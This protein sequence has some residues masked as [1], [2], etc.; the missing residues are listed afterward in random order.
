[1]RFQSNLKKDLNE[2]VR[3]EL[4]RLYRVAYRL[5]GNSV[6]SEDM[7]AQTLLQAAKGWR[8][9][10]GRHPSAWLYRILNNVYLREGAK[11][12]RRATQPIEDLAETAD[13]I[14]VEGL[15]VERMELERVLAGMAYLTPEQQVAVTLCDIEG[16]SYDEV[17]K[18]LEIPKGTLSSRLFRARQTLQEH[19][20][21][22]LSD[23]S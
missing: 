15:V 9:F 18:V 8:I 10:D 4:P 16:M 23:R 3:A 14:D 5:T 7:V 6:D 17:S 22:V 20:G 2:V 19:C 1:M 21:D 11:Q 12:S 13:P